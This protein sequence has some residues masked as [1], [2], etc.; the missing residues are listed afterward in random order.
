MH[1][2]ISRLNIGLSFILVV[3]VMGTHMAA[4]S[5]SSFTIYRVTQKSICTLMKFDFIGLEF[6]FT[7]TENK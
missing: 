5:K 4:F 7:L 1:T 6:F 2:V 3:V